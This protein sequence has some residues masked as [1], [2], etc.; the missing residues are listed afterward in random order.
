MNP[1]QKIKAV[2]QNLNA[3]WLKIPALLLISRTLD[4]FSRIDGS[5]K[6]AGV[7]YYTLLSIFP[8]LL[9]LIALFGYL[10]PALNIQDE[11]LKFV[12]NNLPGA[13][14]I[15]KQ[16]LENIIGLRG[17]IGVLSVILLFWS[18]STMFAALSLAINRAWNIEVVRPFYIRK[19]S[20]LGMSI[21]AG[22]LFLLS[23]GASAGI[24][25]LGKVMDLPA[26]D[27]IFVNLGGRLAAFLLILTI[28]LILYKLLPNT[29]TYWKYIWPGAL[30]SAVLFEIA[31]SL[32]MFYLVSFANYQLIYGSVS[33]IIILLIWI[34]YSSFIL[35]LGA[36]FTFQYA[37]MRSRLKV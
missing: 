24:S 32:F 8:L 25:I 28:F 37:Q 5:Q 19:I 20:E 12:G 27:S 29:R 2:Y 11:L 13:T 10:L 9:G 35:I 23:L 14:D 30:F 4:G 15:I 22:F 21:A 34:Y 6:A 1:L 31:R 16:N 18:A 3:R 17:I 33:S 7:A 36:Q 26:V